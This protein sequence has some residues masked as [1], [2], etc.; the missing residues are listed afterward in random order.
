[1]TKIPD[2]QLPKPQPKNE[3]PA[4]PNDLPKQEE[5][6]LVEPPTAESTA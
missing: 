1:M 2:D 5:K 4:A 3:E 6:E